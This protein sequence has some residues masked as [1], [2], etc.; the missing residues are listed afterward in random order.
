[1]SMTLKGIFPPMITSFREDGEID[2]RGI[3]SVV[4]FLVDREVN[5][6]FIIGSYGSCALMEVGERKLVARSVLK[7]VGERIPVIVHVGAAS[8][9]TTIE[10][11]QDAQA[12][13]AAAVA[14]VIPYYYS[15]IAYKDYEI[16]RHYE[17]LVNNVSLPVYVYNNPRTTG[18]FITADLLKKLVG[19]GVRGMK[20]SSGD[21]MLFAELINEVKPIAPD[22]NFMVGTV[23]LIEPAFL[24]GA[25]SCVAGT[26]IAFPE[27]VRLLF[28]ALNAGD[29]ECASRLQGRVIA[30]RKLQAISGFRPAAC[31]PLLRMRGIAPG[32]VRRP[33][34]EPTDQQC[35]EMKKGLKKLGVL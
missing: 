9:R 21:Y 34:C 29:Y 19:V 12:A 14:A 31:Y 4:D 23:G 18:F 17:E 20:D 33:W 22:F 8:T 30:I 27:V 25:E 35:R 24:L 1:M 28:D 6:L 10:L 5:G 13:G 3:A 16:V 15:A 7:R 11:A 26:A 32:T 2:D